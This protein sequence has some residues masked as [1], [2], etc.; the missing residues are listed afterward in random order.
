MSLI[1][2]AL[3]RSESEQ[4]DVPSIAVSE[5][6]AIR[7]ERTLGW[8]SGLALGLTAL[9]LL[10]VAVWWFWSDISTSGA[11]ADGI[12]AIGDEAMGGPGV[13]TPASS[14]ESQNVR[15]PV[16]PSAE[17]ALPQR[18]TRLPPDAQ[19]L[20]RVSGLDAD[21]LK[22]L[23]RAM[24]EDAEEAPDSVANQGGGSD[25]RRV[26]GLQSNPDDVPGPTPVEWVEPVES[27]QAVDL[28]EV[29]QR[30]AL[31]VGERSLAPHPVALLE[32]LTQQQKDRVPTIIYSAHQYGGDAAFVELNGNRLREG[33]RS[34][35]IRVLE[36]LPDSVVL[37]VAG[38]E[39]RLKALNSWVNF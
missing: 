38:T 32:T 13:E 18:P 30:L 1:L 28:Q 6:N 17:I 27:E 29:M 31:E 39:F 3:R 24:W 15:E 19:A 8:A 16:S 33:A 9:V 5:G 14:I 2:D 12:G 34:D 7:S 23:N 21:E 26:P 11:E 4:R 20:H 22:A 10:C 37:N 35:A 36:I 25:A